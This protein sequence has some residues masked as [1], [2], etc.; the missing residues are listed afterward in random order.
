MPP[1]IREPKSRSD[2]EHDYEKLLNGER[3]RLRQLT[4]SRPGVGLD[5]LFPG[6]G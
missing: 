3:D 1:P 4:V 6:Q 2:K 5:G